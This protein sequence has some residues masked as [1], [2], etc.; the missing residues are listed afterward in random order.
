MTLRPLSTVIV[1]VIVVAALSCAGF[2]LLGQRRLH[3]DRAEIEDL[4]SRYVFALDWQEPE[5]YGDTFTTDGVLIWAGGTVTG[6]AAIV[7]E[8]RKARAADTDRRHSEPPQRPWRRRHFTT[9]LALRVA[10]DHATGRS[11][12]FEFNDD[13]ADRKA[14]VGAYGHSEDEFERVDGQWL[15]KRRQIFNEQRAQMAAGDAIPLPPG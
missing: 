3:D 7:E 14:Y 8:M 1:T 11:Y 5:R 13:N 9:N 12:W 2:S 15:F 6:R 4:L 10:G